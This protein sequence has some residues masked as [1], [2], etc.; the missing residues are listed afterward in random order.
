MEKFYTEK[1]YSDMAIKANEEGK[2]LIKV[3]EE[4]TY[5]V[6]VL[7]WKKKTIEEPVIDPETGE[8]TGE[9]ETIEVDDYTKPIMVEEIDPVTGETITVQKHHTETRT[10]WVERLELV[11][12]DRTG[13]LKTQL[14]A[15]D[16]KTIRSLRAIVA[17][18]ATQAD[19]DFL[20]TLEQQAENIRAELAG[21]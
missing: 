16:K 7:E 4:I 20:A 21:N 17:E 8:P 18:T 10:K 19:I 15:I 5:T 9:T 13:V 1:D 2:R 11:D 6:E 3:Q 12:G 14:D